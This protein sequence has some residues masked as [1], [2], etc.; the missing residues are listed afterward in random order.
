MKKRNLM[1][2]NIQVEK[3]SICRAY[4][5]ARKTWWSTSKHTHTH[6][7]KTS[8]SDFR[9]IVKI[10]ISVLFFFVFSSWTFKLEIFFK[11]TKLR[12]LWM[13]ETVNRD[14]RSLIAGDKIMSHFPFRRSPSNAAQ[15]SCKNFYSHKNRFIYFFEPSI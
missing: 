4:F 2:Y 6:I 10:A 14:R 5:W 13:I 15:V 1:R 12:A 7:H 3:K 9:R 8:A 11:K